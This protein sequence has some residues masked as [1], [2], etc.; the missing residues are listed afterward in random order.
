[1]EPLCRWCRLFPLVLVAACSTPEPS[2]STT[3]AAEAAPESMARASVPD[4][5]SG[6]KPKEAPSNPVRSAGA[7]APKSTTA[8]KLDKVAVADAWVL[9]AMQ[10]H[11]VAVRDA[12]IEKIRAA[13][14]SNDVELAHAGLIA[15]S[16]VRSVSF[17][18]R[19]FRALVLPHLDAPEGARRLAA[20]FALDSVGREAGDLDRVLASAEGVQDPERAQLVHVIAT[21][22]E[23][24]LRGPA[25]SAVSRILA[26]EDPR[27][28]H[29]SLSGLWGTRV[30][31]EIEARLLELAR[32]PDH[33]VAH[34]A[35]YFGLST[36][37][38]KSEAVVDELIRT[39]SHPDPNDSDRALWGLGKGVPAAL[40][41]KVADAALQLFE[42]RIDANTR[43]SCLRLIA[44]YG[45]ERHALA[46]E[47]IASRPVVDETLAKSLRETAAQ[48]RR[49]GSRPG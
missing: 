5:G 28:L 44:Q 14:A 17:D 8:S 10:I 19:P 46:L 25:G 30:S 27:A 33:T 38:D 4:A 15:L 39:L 7:A 41:P 22:S 2:R 32:R 49:R 43:N 9:E 16:R 12:A 35:I 23:G 45:V 48:V 1:M 42:S 47:E 36:L 31:P 26:S 11:D 18:R 34:Y 21:F 29:Q 40:E 37:R 24:D 6:A 20:M 13:L 3:T